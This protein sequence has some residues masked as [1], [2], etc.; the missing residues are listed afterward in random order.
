MRSQVKASVRPIGSGLL[1]TAALL[2]LLWLAV[3][4]AQAAPGFSPAGEFG[5]EEPGIGNHTLGPRIAVDTASG[6]VLTAGR[7]FEIGVSQKLGVNVYDSSGTL[8]GKIGAGSVDPG[9]IAIDQSDG[10]LYVADVAAG[11]V[12]RYT[13]DHAIPPTYTLDPSYSGPTQGSGPGQIGSLDSAIAIDPT[14]RDLLVA[15]SGGLRV[16]RYASGGQ[17]LGSFDGASSGLG[18]FTSLIDLAVDPGGRIYVVQNGTVDVTNGT[19]MV[20]GSRVVRYSP[21]GAEATELAPGGALTYARAVGVD[22]GSGRAVVVT[23]GG[24]FSGVPLALR[25]FATDGSYAS[26]ALFP[27]GGVRLVTGGVAIDSGSGRLYSDIWVTPY[28]GFGS[29]I[30]VKV[31]AP[32]AVPAVNIDPPSGVTPFAAHLTGSVTPVGAVASY[33]FEYSSDGGATWSSAPTEET[34]TGAEAPVPVSADLSLEPVA[35]YTARLVAEDGEGNNVTFPVVFATPP[36]Q[37]VA[38]TGSV[39]GVGT[40]KAHLQGTVNPLGAQASYHFEY[41]TSTAYGSR[42]PVTEGVAGGGRKAI[43]VGHDVTGLLPGT[44]YHYRLVADGPGGQGAGADHTFETPA[45]AP[46]GRA[47]ELVSPLD[48]GNVSVDTSHTTALASPD[49][50]LMFFGTEKASYPGAESTPIIPRVSAART[51][52]GWTDTNLDPPQSNNEQGQEHF[53]GTIAISADHTRAF[54][55]S[56]VALTPGAVPGHV[57]LYIR[58]LRTGAYTF[59]ASEDLSEATGWGGIMF[60]AEASYIGGSADLSTVVFM[61]DGKVLPEAVAARENMYEWQEG[62]GLSLVSVDPNGVPFE[63]PTKKASGYL[64]DPNQVSED[65]RR[66]YFEIPLGSPGAGLYLREDG[67]TTLVSVS[68]RPGDPRVPVPALFARASADGRYAIFTLSSLGAGDPLPP[69][70]PDAPE[71]GTRTSYR[72]DAVTGQLTYLVSD[73]EVLMANPATGDLFYRTANAPGNN[74]FFEHE[75]SSTLV[76]EMQGQQ[77]NFFNA[78]PNGKYFVFK[79][80]LQLTSYDNHGV[81]EVYLYEAERERLVCASC[82]TDGRAPTGVAKIGQAAPDKP[83]GQHHFARSVLDDGTVFFDTTDPLTPGDSNG[84]R[85]VY[86]YRDGEVTLISR[87]DRS[88]ASEFVEATP[89][90]NDVFFSS[91][92]QLVPQDKDEITDLYDA[93]IGGGFPSQETTSGSGCGEAQCGSAGATTA[94]AVASEASTGSAAKARHRDSPKCRKPRHRRGR[95]SASS[96]SKPKAKKAH[97]RTRG[98]GAK[99]RDKATKGAGR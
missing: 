96:C 92:Q 78:S 37:P 30:G 72:Y 7:Y 19:G 27:E 4:P 62:K 68:H 29:L 23:G 81:E 55:A 33:R 85:D 66:I 26:T 10:D 35:T 63:S 91:S 53:Y 84:E 34:P 75:G 15:D 79:S 74:L 43:A 56:K 94:P 8:L 97:K 31:F 99:N 3:A 69:L 52:Q 6:D 24:G 77:I 25:T 54:V 58:D 5:F 2:C 49:G 98:S 47:Y 95:A 60:E 65:G 28:S 88:G 76:A 73:S 46:P 41:G 86:V 40:D 12:T 87:G 38:V 11:K 42:V 83:A 67:K 61:A 36:A 32:T 45:V 18:T 51:A 93:R 13:T 39:S 1:A 14:N 22:P 71:E 89:S 50:N 9:G 16:S 21:D 90:G 59:V 80:S 57:N 17:F 20:V 70:T 64:R 44:V 48:K 82:R